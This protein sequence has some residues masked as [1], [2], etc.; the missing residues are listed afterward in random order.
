MNLPRFTVEQAL[1][2]AEQV[3]DIFPIKGWK[4]GHGD[5]NDNGV[6][7]VIIEVF[8]RA[9]GKPMTFILDVPALDVKEGLR[10][11]ADVLG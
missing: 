2:V 11:L 6:P 5:F 10:K 4:V 9:T 3:V 7:D 1:G 8:F